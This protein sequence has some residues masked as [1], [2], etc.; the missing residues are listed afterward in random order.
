ML[1]KMESKTNSHSL[2][3]RM[4]NGTAT[5]EDTLQL[6]AKLNI[7]LPYDSV[8]MLLGIYPNKLKP[9]IFTKFF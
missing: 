8:I 7:L 1:M 2:L 4:Q 6:L 5:L 9:Y 3:V